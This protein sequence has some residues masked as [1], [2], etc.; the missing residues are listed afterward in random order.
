[1]SVKKDNQNLFATYP[2]ATFSYKIIIRTRGPPS[3]KRELWNAGNELMMPKA[4]KFDNIGSNKYSSAH[5]VLL[6]GTQVHM[7]KCWDASK[8]WMVIQLAMCTIIKSSTQA[9]MQFPVPSYGQDY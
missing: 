1:M 5:V 6:K 8:T 9:C 3:F 7:V 2:L 4:D